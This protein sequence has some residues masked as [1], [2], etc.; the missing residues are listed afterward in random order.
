MSTLKSEHVQLF[1]CR[2]SSSGRLPGAAL[3][4]ALLVD[5]PRHPGSLATKREGVQYKGPPVRTTAVR[6]PGLSNLMLCAS[7]DFCLA[8][9]LMLRDRGLSSHLG[10]RPS[11]HNRGSGPHPLHP[12]THQQA[13]RLLGHPLELGCPSLIGPHPG[14]SVLQP[15]HLPKRRLRSAPQP[16]LASRRTPT[17]LVDTGLLDKATGAMVHTLRRLESSTDFACHHWTLP[18]QRRQKDTRH[19]SYMS[20]TR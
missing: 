3:R 19:D 14:L 10:E 11:G 20:R 4:D 12:V 13:R 8:F 1:K 6:P 15:A 5:L 16:L 2:Q 18:R 7:E 9:P 17:T